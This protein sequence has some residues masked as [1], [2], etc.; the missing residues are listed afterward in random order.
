MGGR[1]WW[2]WW[3]GGGCWWGGG[4]V[5]CVRVYA[6]GPKNISARGVCH[7]L[8]PSLPLPF[9]LSLSSSPSRSRSRSRSRGVFHDP[10]FAEVSE[11]QSTIWCIWGPFETYWPVW[12]ILGPFG[13]YWA[14]LRAARSALPRLRRL[15]STR[16]RS[17]PKSESTAIQR[18]RFRAANSPIDTRRGSA[19]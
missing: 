8:S 7:A 6:N 9:P 11:V 1:A 12:Y 13:A 17:D 2:W 5:E 14:R 16:F 15:D 18:E 19:Q 4:A 3:G 10:I